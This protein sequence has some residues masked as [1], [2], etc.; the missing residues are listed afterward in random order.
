[1]LL[2]AMDRS[3]LLSHHTHYGLS[4]CLGKESTNFPNC[5]GRNHE[6]KRLLSQLQH[7]KMHMSVFSSDLTRVIDTDHVYHI[8]LDE[9]LEIQV[10]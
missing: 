10:D 6:Y 8:I 4:L 2:V 1:M 3:V 9:L 7:K 5:P